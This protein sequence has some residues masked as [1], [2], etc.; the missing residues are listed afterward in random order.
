MEATGY[1]PSRFA[2]EIGI[3]RAIVSHVLAGRNKPSLDMVQ[4]IVRRFP[5]L[6][7]DWILDDNALPNGVADIKSEITVASTAQST[8]KVINQEVPFA[9]PMPQPPP[10]TINQPPAPVTPQIPAI[11]PPLPTMKRIEKILVFYT[12]KTF[13]EYTPNT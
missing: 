5:E 4:K 7:S 12:D 8:Q 1:T 13:D 2:D 10:M 6:G 11:V 3:P 9:N